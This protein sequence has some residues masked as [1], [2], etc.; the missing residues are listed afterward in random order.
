[1]T[2]LA[3]LLLRQRSSNQIGYSGAAIVVLES[4]HMLAKGSGMPPLASETLSGA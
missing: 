4:S 2:F 1:M 3:F